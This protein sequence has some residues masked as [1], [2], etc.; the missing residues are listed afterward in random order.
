MSDITDAATFI[1][2]PLGIR[3]PETEVL[4]RLRNDRAPFALVGEWAGGGAVL[5]SEPTAWCDSVG[6][7]FS[8]L[9]KPAELAGFRPETWRACSE[10]SENESYAPGAH[11][12][13]GGGWVGWLGYGAAEAW[14]QT[15]PAPGEPRRLSLCSFAYYDH[16]LRAD[17]GGEWFFEAL[18][19]AGRAAEIDERLVILGQRMSDSTSQRSASP[20]GTVPKTPLEH[21]RV[22]LGELA[23][24]PAAADHEA[25][26]ARCVELIARG[27]L[28]QANL[29]MRFEGVLEGDPLELFCEAIDRLHPPYA[30][31]VARDEGAVVSLSPELFL[32]RLGRTVTSRPIKGTARRNNDPTEAG[33]QR[34]AL[35]SSAKDRAENVMI[36]DL[37]RND[38]GRVC[39]TGSVRVTRLCVPEPHPGV[40]HLVSEVTG[41]LCPPVGDAELIRATFPP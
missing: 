37:V 2:R 29:C 36:V 26:V 6:S 10:G 28:L 12:P 13:F 15:P 22:T 24:L 18:V 41:E 1:R 38:L 21:A 4:R 31:F 40:W 30:A 5:G 39:T 23:S 14:Q 25:A 9:G 19:T 35:E 17:S 16:V 20:P 33:A 7:L 27:D 32:R 11:A 8:A 34:R 3:M